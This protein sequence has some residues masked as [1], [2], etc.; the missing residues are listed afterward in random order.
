VGLGLAAP[1]CGAALP[2]Q[3]VD[4]FP[5]PGCSGPLIRAVIR[6][7]LAALPI[8]ILPLIPDREA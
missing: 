1:I 5:I 2:F 6:V 4:P 3:G 8:P 7:R